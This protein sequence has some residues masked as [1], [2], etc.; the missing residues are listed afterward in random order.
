MTAEERKS[1]LARVNDLVQADRWAEALSQ[2]IGARR[3][4]RWRGVNWS[5]ARLLFADEV[6]KQLKGE[7]EDRV[8]GGTLSLIIAVGVASLLTILITCKIRSAVA[9]SQK[10]LSWFLVVVFRLCLRV[11]LLRQFKARR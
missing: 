10:N 9:T 4:R 1:I 6:H 11:S 2:V 5:F 8:D 3:R 7:P